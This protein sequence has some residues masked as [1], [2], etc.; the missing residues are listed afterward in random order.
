[1]ISPSI[2]PASQPLKSQAKDQGS[3]TSVRPEHM[4]FLSMTTEFQ[5]HT[6]RT[7]TLLGVALR[8]VG[9]PLDRGEQSNLGYTLTRFTIRESIGL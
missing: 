6:A 4:T 5:M 7:R 9:S 3:Y 2:L 8:A 1:M